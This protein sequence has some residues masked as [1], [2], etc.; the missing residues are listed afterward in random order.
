MYRTNIL[1]LGSTITSDLTIEWKGLQTKETFKFQQN[2]VITLELRQ[3]GGEARSPG[4]KH[5]NPISVCRRNCCVLTKESKRTTPVV[6]FQRDTASNVL[7]YLFV[8][9]NICSTPQTLGDEY[10]TK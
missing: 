5:N 4:I 10:K 8:I 3:S 7:C 9:L 2:I 6:R 1:K